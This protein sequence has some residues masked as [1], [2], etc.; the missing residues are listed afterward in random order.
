[1]AISSLARLYRAP[2]PLRHPP[3]RPRPR[4]ARF[5]R[6]RDYGPFNCSIHRRHSW[7]RYYRGCWHRACPPVAFAHVCAV[8][9][10]LMSR[11]CLLAEEWAISAPAAVL[12]RGSHL[13]GSLSGTKPLFPVTRRRLG[14]PLHYQHADRAASQSRLLATVSRGYRAPR[15][16]R[17]SI[18]EP[19][20]V[21][22]RF[23]DMHG[24][25][26]ETSIYVRQNQ[27]GAR[28][29]RAAAANCLPCCPAGVSCCVHRP[30]AP[31]VVFLAGL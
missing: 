14:S 3:R 20:V 10:S 27:P 19:F 7:S 8:R 26:S 11:D 17:R 21:P 5:R 28:R 6:G 13:S 18:T 16:D 29:A 2:C 1:M 15:A 12:G 23:T 25:I 24:L 4:A 30:A 9:S 22:R 31:C